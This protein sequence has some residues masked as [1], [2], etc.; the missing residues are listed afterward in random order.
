MAAEAA[1]PVPMLSTVTTVPLTTSPR[2]PLVRRALDRLPARLNPTVVRETAW[3]GGGFASKLAI[4]MATLFYLTRNLG[5]AGSGTFFAM[6]SLMACLVPFVQMGN[7]DL[8]VRDIA[9]RRD[10]PRA[11]AGRAMRGS[12]AA[13]ALVLPIVLCLRPWV[14][15]QVSW[16]AFVAVTAGELLVMRVTVN[17]QAVATGF[18]LHYVAAV[19]DLVLGV[20]RLAAVYVADRAHAGVDA[21]LSLYALTSL[22]AA[23]ATYAWLCHRVGRPVVRGGPLFAELADHLRMVVAWFAEMAAQAGDKPLL[24]ALAGPAAVGIYGT[25]TKLYVI[26]L[27]P[28]DVLSQ[29]LR[30]RLG[31]AYGDSEADGRRLYRLAAAGLFGCGL[32]TGGALLAAALLVPHVAP[33]LLRGPFADARVALIYLA[34]LPPIYGLQRANIIAAISRGA[35]SA[36]ARATTVAAVAGLGT[37]VLFAHAHGWRAACLA[38]QVYLCTSCLAIYLLTRAEARR[39]SNPP[40][41]PVLPEL[42]ALAQT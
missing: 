9:R 1:I 7:Y 8:T 11:V 41:D 6:V 10:D 20:S 24:S 30:P 5:V 37:L 34:F 2:A 36:Y 12:A 28:I 13:F 33:K 25:A 15:P 19:S 16:L 21:E 40:A 17:V 39:A 4:Q 18:R 23:A 27:V 22:P 3:L 14:A 35:T 38:A 26:M 32:M 31:R 42:E 29:V